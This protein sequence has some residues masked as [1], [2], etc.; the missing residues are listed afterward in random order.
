MILERTN[1][2]GIL[3]A[4]GIRDKDLR[5][6]F[7]NL[8]ARIIARGLLWGNIAGIGIALLQHW[9][10]ILPLDEESYYISFVPISLNVMH[11]LLINAGTFLVCLLMVL[12]PGYIIGRITPVK[13]IG[14]R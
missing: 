5:K 8:T 12:I 1:M 13:A 9:T 10:K 4:L 2:I 14:F 7:V 6:L 11:I 3:K